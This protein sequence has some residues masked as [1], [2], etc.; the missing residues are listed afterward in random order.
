MIPIVYIVLQGHDILMAT[1]LTGAAIMD[2][3]FLLIASN[4]SC[5]PP[6]QTLGH[7]AAVE[8]MRLMYIIILQHKIDLIQENI[9][10]NQH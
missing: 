8:L 2:G 3:A 9:A 7:L 10:I 6:T 5:P 4:E 1:I